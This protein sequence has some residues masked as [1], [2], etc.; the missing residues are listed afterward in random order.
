M[1]LQ[2]AGFR[3]FPS[4][5]SIS[6]GHVD[7]EPFVDNQPR[8]PFH[9]TI[10]QLYLVI[11]VRPKRVPPRLRLKARG[12]TLIIT[13]MLQSRTDGKSSRRGECRVGG[14]SSSGTA[15]AKGV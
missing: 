13:S 14:G 10:G 9:G 2:D 15:M 8:V 6:I 5:R 12:E 7:R 1:V 11:P 4:T 3:R